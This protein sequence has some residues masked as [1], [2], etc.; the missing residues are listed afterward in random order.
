MIT[1]LSN[2]LKTQLINNRLNNLS[3]QYF[4]LEMDKAQAQSNGND[5]DL[6]RVIER[7]TQLEKTYAAIEALLP[8][9]TTTA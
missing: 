1:N 6:Q 9:T 4:E 2:D 5:Q 7:M 8:T 3:R